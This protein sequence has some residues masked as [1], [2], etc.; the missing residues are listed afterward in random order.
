MNCE[1]RADAR[2]LQCKATVADLQAEVIL[3]CGL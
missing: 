2:G 3:S 1:A